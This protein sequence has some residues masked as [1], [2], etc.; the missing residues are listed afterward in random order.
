MFCFIYCRMM[1]S[2][3]VFLL[4]M[5]GLFGLKQNALIPVLLIPL[6]VICIIFWYNVNQMFTK[7]CASL[8]FTSCTKIRDLG[9]D[10]IEVNIPLL[11]PIFHFNRT[12]LEINTE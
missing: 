11:G 6:L 7:Q 5:M 4:F 2:I 8:T 1:V 3:V 10:L 9:P 12:I